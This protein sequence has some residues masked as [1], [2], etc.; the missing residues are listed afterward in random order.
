[1]PPI[2][3]PRADAGKLLERE[4]PCGCERKERQAELDGRRSAP[5]LHPLDR[6]QE[7]GPTLRMHER[8]IEEAP[9]GGTQP[10]A[11]QRFRTEKERDGHEE[12]GICSEV[13]QQR[14]AWRRADGI[15]LPG[16]EQQQR[17]PGE[18][19]EPDTAAE[20]RRPSA[21]DDAETLHD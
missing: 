6:G 1:M 18:K 21:L 11:D 10:R 4:E 9:S 13:E 3:L 17:D 14:R 12:S 5:S 20:Y 15:A 2:R 8:A 16:G 19:Y 7:L